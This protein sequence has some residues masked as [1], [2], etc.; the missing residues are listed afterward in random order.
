VRVGTD[1]VGVADVR[2]SISR[3]GDRYLSRVFTPRELAYC[4]ARTDA[5]VHLAARFAAKEATMKVLRPSK[6]E[7][8][9]WL[10][11][12][13]VRAPEGHCDVALT[14]AAEALAHRARIT[15]LGVSLSHE[16]HYATAVVVAE[17]D[18][19]VLSV[20]PRGNAGMVRSRRR[21]KQKE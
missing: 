10:S 8:I 21:E 9:D 20:Q 19:D 3:F 18:P 14:G 13:L 4:L 12:E 2:A 1:I 11:I 16:T 5:P 15:G 7:A 17:H 6:D